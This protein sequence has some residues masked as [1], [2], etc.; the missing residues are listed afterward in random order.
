[1][2]WSAIFVYEAVR[3]MVH[4]GEAGGM[5]A[6]TA[7]FVINRHLNTLNHPATLTTKAPDE[8]HQPDIIWDDFKKEGG[9]ED[10]MDVIQQSSHRCENTRRPRDVLHILYDKWHVFRSPLHEVYVY[11]VFYD[12][13]IDNGLFPSLRLLAVARTVKN[14]T[15]CQVWYPSM[16]QPVVKEAKLHK[17]GGG[18]KLNKTHYEQYYFT[19]GLDTSYPIPNYVSLVA[20]PC[21]KA[22]NYIAIYVPIRAPFKH[23]FA[24]CVPVA[25]NTVNPYRLTEWLEVNKILGVTEINIYHVAMSN[26]TL[27]IL[28][29]YEKTGLVKLHHIPSVPH[30]E[31]GR[32]GNKIGSPI[33]LNDCMYRNM[34]RYKWILFIDFDELIVP[35]G[36]KNLRD[37]LIS[38]DR[39]EKLKYSPSSYTF[40]NVYFWAGCGTSARKP[41]KAYA[42][43][44]LLREQP[45]KFLYAAK[46][47]IDPRRCI[48]VF[49]HYCYIRFPLRDKKEKWTIDVKTSSATSH[50]YRELYQ[51]RRS[52]E[53]CDFL[54]KN[55]T[56]DDSILR[57]K[58]I[59]VKRIDKSRNSLRLP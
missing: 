46:S 22:D 45:N 11:S 41:D 33:S 32:S 54:K 29:Y 16:T 35:R 48:S 10:A 5:A 40:R 19:C 14:N 12:E 18:H 15:Y 57:W 49:N 58:K 44:Y 20:G 9:Y 31:K 4:M 39:E 51:G 6:D 59:L 23:D 28:E 21:D 7:G 24:I 2:G 38:I 36:H 47:I 52:K 42:L 53:K 1:M 56:R 25:F 30:Y 17:N 50:H 34:Y 3:Q 26:E 13:R 55:G 43:K 27:R 8:P 37:L